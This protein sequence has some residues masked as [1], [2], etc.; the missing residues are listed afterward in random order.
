MQ[1]IYNLLKK[2]LA[3]GTGMLLCISVFA[4]QKDTAIHAQSENDF[5]K[6]NTVQIPEDVILEVGGMVFLPND[7]LAV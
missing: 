7:A 5:Y 6:I 1:T 3:A 2:C 4:Q